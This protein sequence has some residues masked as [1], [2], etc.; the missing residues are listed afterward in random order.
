MDNQFLAPIE[1]PK[2][3]SKQ[4]RLGKELLERIYQRSINAGGSFCIVLGAPGS[5]KTSSMLAI[6]KRIIK[7]NPNELVYWSSS[8]GSPLQFFPFYKYNI[9]TKKNMDIKFFDR[10]KQEEVELPHTEFSTFKECFELSKPGVLN[11]VFFGSRPTWMEYTEFLMSQGKWITIAFDELSEVC[12]SFTSGKMFKQIGRFASHVVGQ[13]R[14]CQITIL[15]NQQSPVDSDYRVRKK[16]NF[17]I[18]FSGAR[19]DKKASRVVQKAVDNLNEDHTNGSQCYISSGGKFGVCRF[20]KPLYKPIPNISIEART[21]IRDDYYGTEP[22]KIIAGPSN[23]R[24]RFDPASETS[25]LFAYKNKR[26]GNI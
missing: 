1:Q 10:Y 16:L 9:L 22:E 8:Y 13:S 25:E 5:G 15:S 3:T 2:Q 17:I 7:N 14:K 11:C 20:G 4:E 19:V 23:S 21:K 12:P 18:Y 26:F 24:G 6:C